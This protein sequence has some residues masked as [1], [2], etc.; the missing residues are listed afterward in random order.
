MLE[1]D[2]SKARD[3][4]FAE[5]LPHLVWTMLPD[6]KVD[7][8]NTRWREYTG[9][10]V[11][12][13][14]DAWSL[15][16]PEDVPRCAA[17][18]K[19]SLESGNPYQIEY[20][21]RRADGIYRWHLALAHAIRDASGAILKWLGTS[22]DIDD[23]KRAGER[24]AFLGKTSSALGASLDYE[25]T[26][27]SI[28]SAAVPEFADACAMELVVG[29]G[30]LVTRQVAVAHVDPAKA[31]LMRLFREKYPVDPAEP[32]GTGQVIRSGTPE[33]YPDIPDALIDATARD[34]EYA[35][36][37]R[38]IGLKSTITVPLAVRGTAIGTLSFALGASDRRYDARDVD[39]ALEVGRRAAMAIDN[40]RLYKRAKDE[41]AR[42]RIA[43]DAGHMGSWDWDISSGEV[44]WSPS[45]EQIHGVP[46]GSFGG[47]VDAH[48]QDIHPDVAPGCSRRF[49]ARSTTAP[50]TTSRTASFVPMA[51]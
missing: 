14:A 47:T 25:K 43:M 11:A 24:E 21:L 20:R 44:R 1:D 50:S 2:E 36:L 28:V 18:W 17:S 22:T 41:E 31:P 29:E 3:R 4:A 39:V 35:Q 32:H 51:R 46:V 5:S 33:F 48:H 13:K 27:A 34:A 42:L 6:G 23:Q 45:L 38:Q 19:A 26:L 12:D 30:G 37:L 40:A 9:I 7:F 8:L 15:V 10:G 49:A 16:H